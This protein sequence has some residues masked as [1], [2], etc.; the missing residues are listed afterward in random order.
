M[1]QTLPLLSP[2]CHKKRRMFAKR[3]IFGTNLYRQRG[4]VSFAGEEYVNYRLH[5]DL[6]HRQRTGAA[7]GEADSKSG[8]PSH[9]RDDLADDFGVAAIS[10]PFKTLKFPGMRIHYQHSVLQ[11]AT[12]A[13]IFPLTGQQDK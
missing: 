11:A 2:R 5:R 4:Y 13:E 9:E 3:T 10:K 12:G 1:R 7:E 6:K 8:E